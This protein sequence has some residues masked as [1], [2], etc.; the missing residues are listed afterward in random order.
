MEH[1]HSITIS[2]FESGGGA[3]L[4]A[5]MKAPDSD[6]QPISGQGFRFE[7]YDCGPPAST[8]NSSDLDF[9]GC[10][11]FATQQAK[12]ATLGATGPGCNA[13]CDPETSG[14]SAT[15]SKEK[16]IFVNVF[17]AVAGANPYYAT[18]DPAKFGG[19]Y[20]KYGDGPGDLF[21][22]ANLA[23]VKRLEDVMIANE[24]A[25][26]AKD[27]DDSGAV[28]QCAAADMSGGFAAS[29]ASCIGREVT[30]DEGFD[31]STLNSASENCRYN[32]GYRAF[33]RIDQT[34]G[35]TGKCRKIYGLMNFFYPREPPPMIEQVIQLGA[36]FLRDP[37][38]PSLISGR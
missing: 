18:K 30:L 14:C 15:Q 33:C 34:A 35:G 26:I 20:D 21:T 37:V 11:P 10:D 3:G 22:E 6:W 7:A 38:S 24:E 17:E 28:L 2:F 5:G 31:L 25:C 29:M 4:T 32:P 23:E 12:G 27:A 13:L 9:S 8:T 1:R 16:D 19:E 36:V